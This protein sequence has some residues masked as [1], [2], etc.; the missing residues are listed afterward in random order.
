MTPKRVCAI[1]G[2]EEKHYSKSLCSHHYYAYWKYGDP[3]H[4]GVKKRVRAQRRHAPGAV[5][6]IADCSTPPLAKGLCRKHY[7][8]QRAHGDPRTV[9]RGPK[10]KGSIKRGYV[11]LSVG[12][13]SGSNVL[14]H[15]FI[16]AQ[17]LGRDLLP[18]ETVHHKNGIR[19]DNR[20]VKGHEVFCPSTCCNL[21]LWSR[22]QPS[23]QR[24]ADKLAW[25]REILQRYEAE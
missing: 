23:G 18:G 14:A 11:Y 25:A 10:G 24:V 9:L 13:R 22:S 12:G 6:S 3:L 7:Q 16:M 5:C 20:L 2:C 17:S 1:E 4:E 15:R 8:R 21:E 19:S